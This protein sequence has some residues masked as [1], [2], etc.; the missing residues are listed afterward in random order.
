MYICLQCHYAGDRETRVK[1][2]FFKEVILWLI[3]FPAGIIYSIWRLWTKDKVCPI[4][5]TPDMI[6]VGTSRGRELLQDKY[7]RSKINT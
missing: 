2:T 3:F 6:P 7:H 1:G 4:C 5:Y